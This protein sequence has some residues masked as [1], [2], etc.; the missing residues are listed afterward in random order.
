LTGTAGDDGIVS[1]AG[2]DI[3]SALEGNDNVYAG[4][5]NDTVHGG[6]GNDSLDG[7]EG[8]DR[9][10][11]DAGDDRLFGGLGND[12]VSGGA[13]N[14]FLG[15]RIDYH[16]GSDLMSGDQFFGGDGLDTLFFGGDYVYGFRSFDIT[17]LAIGTDI[18]RIEA[19]KPVTLTFGQLSQF[20]AIT[21][22]FYVTGSGV[23]DLTANRFLGGTINL[24]AAADTVTLAGNASGGWLNGGGGNDTLIGS[25]RADSLTGGIGD[26]RLEGRG[27]DDY[28]EGGDGNDTVLGGEGNDSIHDGHGNDLMD[29]GLGDDTF[30]ANLYGGFS[31]DDS[32]VGGGGFD[33]LYLEADRTMKPSSISLCSISQASKGWSR[34]R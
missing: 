7:Q 13:G 2:D 15:V 18:E 10:N 30:F 19:E 12:I 17:T 26:D 11:G 24:G 8:D 33:T 25:E 21:G 27:G 22:I 5:G 20:A 16:R 3:V 23:L 34:H 29:G 28:L 6:E 9:I 31:P 32:I 4:L 1:Y 14:D